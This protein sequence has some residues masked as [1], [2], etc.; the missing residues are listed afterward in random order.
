[1]IRSSA[2]TRWQRRRRAFHSLWF[3]QTVSQLGSQVSLVVLPVV[4]VL[5]LRATPFEVGLLAALETA[6]YLVASLPAGVLADRFDRRSLLI[7]TDLARAAVLSIVT[8]AYLAGA[9]SL[10]LLFAVALANG[11]LSVV[12]DVAY[13]SYLPEL[14][15][16]RDLI[17][18]NQKLEV[19]NS[20]A[21]VAGPAL[22]GLLMAAVG[23]AVAVVLDSISYVV[24]AVA[25]G[26]SPRPDRRRSQAREAPGSDGMTHGFAVLA[27]DRVLRDLAG[28]TATFNLASS[29]IFAVLV[30][31]ATR[32]VG[33]DGA[34][35]GFLY[36]LGNLGFLVGALLVGRWTRRLGP[37]P[38][39]YLA[40]VLGAIAT[41]LLP[42]A[43]G[44][45]AI[46]VLAAGRFVGALGA[47]LFNVN[48]YSICQARV[49]N[50]VLGRVNATFRLLEWGALPIGS[51]VGG[52]VG[53]LLGVRYALLMAA[54]CGVA[55]ALWLTF[56]PLRSLAGLDR[57]PLLL[58]SEPEL[59]TRPSG[60]PK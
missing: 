60:V 34:S 53:S 39:L 12:F 57:A 45:L 59:L 46:G 30:V 9:L 23:A 26:A 20:G 44:P 48:A 21:Q 40:A 56:S 18:A 49:A 2:E 1:M 42:L 4:A 55:S 32:D 41:C 52:V 54:V 17:E 51:L 13:Q 47:A 10:P 5:S 33:M 6:P 24:S 35:F 15:S 22:A 19:S 31:F 7:V 27:A 58:P 8:I 37:G 29:M 3:G 28:S 38:T 14:V 16:A 25:L 36:G 50:A 43:G 11:T